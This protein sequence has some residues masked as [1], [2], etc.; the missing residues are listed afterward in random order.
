VSFTFNVAKGREA[1]FASLPLGNDALRL[2]F[3]ETA[4]IEAVETLRD[5][6]TLAALLAGSSNEQTD[7][8]RHTLVNVTVTQDNV[9]NRA[10]IDADD[11][12]LVAP[13]GSAVSMAV[14]VYVPDTTAPSDATAVPVSAHDYVWTP[15]GVNRTV[16][17]SDLIHCE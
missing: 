15:A 3:L 16:E 2:L 12:D 8:G 6:A 7:L 9:N 17:I 1:Q 4:G 14:V 5:H 13:T 10:N 11:V